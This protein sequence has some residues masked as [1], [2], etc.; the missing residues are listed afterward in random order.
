MQETHV[1]NFRKLIIGVL[2]DVMRSQKLGAVNKSSTLA[3][4]SQILNYC[5]VFDRVRAQNQFY[6]IWRTTRFR[7]KIVLIDDRR[8]KPRDFIKNSQNGPPRGY[9]KLYFF[10]TNIIHSLIINNF[11]TCL[12]LSE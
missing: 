4:C 8:L 11:R 12:L 5:I 9:Q 2:Y 7:T 10:M 6:L 3:T 1:Y